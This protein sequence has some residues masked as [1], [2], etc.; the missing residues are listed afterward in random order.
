MAQLA[1]E[2]GNLELNMAL[3]ET[4]AAEAARLRVDLLNLPEAADWGWLHQ[5]ARRDALPVPG[6]YTDFLGA[7]ARR[8]NCWISAGCL[9]KDGVHVYNSAVTIDRAGKIVLKHRKIDTLPWLTKDLYEAGCA[10]HIQVLDTEFGRIGLTICAD[11]FN[12]KCPLRVAELGA[13]LLVAPY[14][15][16]AE[17]SRLEQNSEEFQTHILS[18]AAGTGLW[19]IGTNSVQGAVQG[20]PW[21]GWV[22]SG[23][24]TIGRPDGTAGATGKFA[25]PDLVVVDVHD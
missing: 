8:F 2:D 7:L 25:E 22:H 17:P 23:C 9:E 24:S 11:N 5:H 15:F 10:D 1:I 19:V 12:L 4:A 20:G 13:W 21:K 14:G 18:V 16:A 3:A 6:K